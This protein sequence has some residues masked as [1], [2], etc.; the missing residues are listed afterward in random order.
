ME[1]TLAIIKP[2]AVR[3]GYA[4][5]IKHRIREEGFTI[6]QEKTLRLST[7]SVEE[8]YKEHA[9]KPFYPK[10]VKFMSR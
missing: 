4:A 10:L 9:G 8:F 7:Q 2:D 1:T 6:I 5:D 3:K